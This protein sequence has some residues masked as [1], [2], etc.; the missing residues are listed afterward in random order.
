M[1]L[2]QNL[3]PTRAVHQS[4]HPVTLRKPEQTKMKTSILRSVF[5]ALIAGSAAASGA[6]MSAPLARP[7]SFDGNWSVVIHTRQGDCGAS[8]RYSLRIVGGQVQSNEQ[9]YRAAG[10]V[11]RNGSVRVVVAGGDRSARGAGGAGG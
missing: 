3:R 1:R 7:S 2:A 5:V 8:L 11:A 10:T 9:N 6:A 4:R